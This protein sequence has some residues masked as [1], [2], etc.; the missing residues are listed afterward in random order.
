MNVTDADD[1]MLNLFGCT[2]GFLAY[3]MTRNIT[4]IRTTR[5]FDT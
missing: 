2:I 1:L 5:P 4:L 3:A